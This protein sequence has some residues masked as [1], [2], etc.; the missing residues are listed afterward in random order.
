LK[1]PMDYRL[2]HILTESARKYPTAP[3]II[4][5]K[6]V[7]SYEHLEEESNRLANALVKYGIKRGDR[8]GIYM[9][10]SISSII[11]VFG[12]LKA[13]GTYVPIDP[14]APAAR[15]EYILKTCGIQSLISKSDKMRYLERTN[16]SELPLKNVILMDSAE[17]LALGPQPLRFIDWEKKRI[18]FSIELPRIEMVDSELAYILFTSGSTGNPKGVMISHLNSLT[19]VS[20]AYE[21]FEI[22]TGDRFSNICPLHFDMSVFDLYVA[23]K[24]GAAVCIIP[25]KTAMF[26]S[27]IAAFIQESELTVWNSVPSALSLLAN[28]SKLEKYDLLSL[29]LILFAG[30]QFPIKHL[31]RLRQLMPRARFFNLYGQTEANSSTYFEIGEVAAASGKPLPIGKPLANY[32]VFALDEEG[33]TIS[34]PGVRGELFVRGSAVAQGYWGDK[35]KTEKSFVPNPLSPWLTEKVYKTGDLVTLDEQGNYIFLGRKDHMIKSRGYRIELGEIEHV[36]GNH[37]D[38]RIVVVVPLPDELIGNRIVAV[39]VM[40]ESKKPKSDDIIKYCSGKLPKYMIPERI[41]FL[42]AV[43]TTSSGKP[44]RKRLLALLQGQEG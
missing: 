17:G 27:Q 23:L 2:E 20:S 24:G 9:N 44:D 41:V 42:D 34:R 10:R 30:E 6:E 5:D 13:G 19:F 18:D 40:A 21:R 32:D 22:R 31:A 39:L 35:E 26:P 3:A 1:Q 14:G 25:E 37:P 8:L 43:L 16:L 36:L 4:C 29:R 11:A 28:Y 12:I 15:I 38:I 33:Q 7:I